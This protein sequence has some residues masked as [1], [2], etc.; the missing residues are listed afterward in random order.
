MYV[1]S[2]FYCFN[3][4]VISP[5]SPTKHQGLNRA[6]SFCLHFGEITSNSQPLNRAQGREFNIQEPNNSIPSCLKKTGTKGRRGREVIFQKSSSQTR[7][8]FGPV[9]P[10]CWDC[11][12]AGEPWPC[13]PA[14]ENAEW[15]GDGGMHTW[16]AAYNASGISLQSPPA[17]TNPLPEY[18]CIPASL[19][20]SATINATHQPPIKL[21]TQRQKWI[22]F[23]F[24][25]K[26]NRIAVHF[27]RKS[28]PCRATRHSTPPLSKKTQETT[29]LCVAAT[30][31]TV[32][33]S[34]NRGRLVA[35]MHVQPD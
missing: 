18:K 3:L 20:K 11:V 4:K 2:F 5:S 32:V 17:P 29:V 25:L 15:D 12:C 10:T 9:A 24:H 31:R 19:Q 26:V 33:R 8:R 21:C 1:Y 6:H 30:P 35:A 13:S 28:S 34:K 7:L 22:D 27:A 23:E 14:Q 16:P